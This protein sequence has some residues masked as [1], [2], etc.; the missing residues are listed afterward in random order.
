MYCGKSE[1]ELLQEKALQSNDSGISFT[2]PE[3]STRN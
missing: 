1:R 2:V 3:M